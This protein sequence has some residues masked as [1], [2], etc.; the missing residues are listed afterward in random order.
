[1]LQEKHYSM[2][3]EAP[4]YDVS[5]VEQYSPVR[6]SDI[7]P[8]DGAA[9]EAYARMVSMGATIYGLASVYQ[10]REMY[11]QAVN[12]AGSDYVGFNKFVHDRELA[13]PGYK[14]FKSPN[15]DTMY[16]NAWLNLSEGP[17]LIEIPAFGE[18]YYTLQLLDMYANA[19][20]ISLRTSGAGEGKYL[21]ATTDWEGQVPPGFIPYKVSTPYQWILMRIFPLNASDLAE[22]HALQEA[23]RITPL[24]SGEKAHA[25]RLEYPPAGQGGP[26]PFFRI[27]DFVL[28]TNGKP[29]QEEGLTSCYRSIGIGTKDPFDFDQLDIEVQKGMIAGYDDAMTVIAA[30]QSQLGMPLDTH[31]VKTNSKGAYGFNYLSR[32]AVNYVGLGANVVEENQSFVTFHDA[33]GKPLDGSKGQYIFHMNTTPPVDA[34]WSVTLYDANTKELYPNAINRFAI[35]DRTAG[36]PFG[37]DGS[38]TITIQHERPLN[39]ANWLPAP[40]GPFYLSIR[41]YMP[42]KELLE[43]EWLPDGVKY[44]GKGV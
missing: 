35:N 15:V 23:V 7:V 19:S 8:R 20:N 25:V 22:V 30:S 26:I 12:E 17:L 34:F 32:A 27:L 11:R 6:H 42:R 37:S 10:Y 33:D 43:G 44:V 40:N 3:N 13:R 29:L 39:D 1:M 16:S 4:S 5:K 28:R 24:P 38:V 31:W 14:A 9:R 41:A 2:H 18:R 36:F 21:I